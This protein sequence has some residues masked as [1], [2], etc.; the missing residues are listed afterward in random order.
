MRTHVII[1]GG[2]VS[3]L[4]AGVLLTTQG[5]MVTV[6]EQKPA[7]GGRAYSY[8]DAVTGDVV[9]NGQHVLIAGYERT[10]HFL[11]IIGARE[12]LTIQKTPL[13]CF[14][15]AERG[16]REFRLPP[17]PSPLHLI[18]GILTSSLFLFRDRLRLLRAGA[19]L[20]SAHP[21][22]DE[23]LRAMTVE[24]WLDSVGQSRECKISFWEPL[25]VS[26]MNEHIDRA[27]AALFVRS[28]AKAFLHGRRHAA[29][30]IPHVGLSQLYAEGAQKY[31]T[32]HGGKVLCGVD[33]DGVDITDGRVGGVRLRGNTAIRGDAV[34]LAVPPQKLLAILTGTSL[35]T[36]LHPI[37]S[38]F[39][40]S[41]IVSIHLWFTSEWMT[42]DVVGLVGRRVQ[43]VFNK[44]MINGET[45][46]GGHISAVISAAHEYVERTNEELVRIAVEDLRS[47]YPDAVEEPRHA[48]V[49]REKSA[50]FSATPA[51][52]CLRP[53]QATEIPNLF[54]AGDW[55]DTGY[56]ATIEGAVASAESCVQA[57]VHSLHPSSE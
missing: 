29:L 42:R 16:F 7:L 54:F 23:A 45:G 21:A 3:G 1:V 36:R 30:A 27:S 52:E 57:I 11:D 14:H 2:G 6:L 25:A 39:D 47:V 35:A 48:V 31:I 13:L 53:P 44:R 40:S 12:F 38:S 17:L 8:T 10:M 4:A 34:I 19:A 43:W 33:V 49:I 51:I 5:V 18:W 15:V 55:T 26:I 9:D 46:K 28:V 50:T 56:P 24:Q 37:L 32:L 20:A 22:T 41:P